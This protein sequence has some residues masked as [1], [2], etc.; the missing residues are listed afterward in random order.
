V[1]SSVV[2]APVTSASATVLLVEDEASVR[3]L[4][5]RILD[6]AGYRVLEAVDGNDAERVFAHHAGSIDLVV[7]DVIMPGCG[8]PELL[9]RLQVQAP[10]L[11]VLY[12]SGYTD[13]SA[14]EKAGIDRGLPFVQKLSDDTSTS[15]DTAFAKIHSRVLGTA[16]AADVIGA[17]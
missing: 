12:M 17:R 1:F 14:V 11:R 5:K 13:Q 8:G 4:S 3:Q 16:L 2:T 10:A 6:H 15:R 9:S 7:T